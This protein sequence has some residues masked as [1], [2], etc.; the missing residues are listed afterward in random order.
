MNDC[1]DI[2]YMKLALKLS[3]NAVGLTEPNPMVGA[4]AVKDNQ[5]VAT[6]FHSRFGAPHAEREA[7]RNVPDG[8]TLYVTMEPCCHVGKTPACT[9]IIMEKKSAAS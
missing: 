3:R 8:T 9:D 6:G 4:V 2:K 7:L 5:I 1:Q